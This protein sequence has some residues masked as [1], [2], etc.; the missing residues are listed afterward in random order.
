MHTA[1]LL[2]GGNIGNREEYLKQAVELLRRQAGNPVRL[3]ALYETAA[4]GNK[5]QE[6]FLN[7]AVQLETQL[8]AA[9]LMTT[10]LGIEE[11][12]GRKRLYKY[13]PRVIDIDILLYDQEIHTSGHITLPHPELPNRRFALEP[14]NELAPDLLHPVLKKSIEDLLLVCQD[15]LPVKKLTT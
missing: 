6:P 15:P 11:E 13:S 7:Q 10:I 14:L 4:W 8:K 5:N 3:S 9:E 12:I 1:Y 2:M